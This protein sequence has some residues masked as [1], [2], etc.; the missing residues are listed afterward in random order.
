MRNITHLVVHCTA[1]PKNTTI[2]SIRKHWKEGL[3]WK[4]VGYHKII[5][6][7]GNITTLATDDKVT[8]FRRPHHSAEASHRRGASIVVAEIS[9]G[10]HLRTQG[11]PRGC[12]GMPAV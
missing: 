3:G 12:E 8:R 2:A 1:T 10:P 4:A 6:P 9:Q 11:L 7:N 5:E